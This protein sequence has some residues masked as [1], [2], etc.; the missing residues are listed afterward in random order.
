MQFIKKHNGF[1]LTELIVVIAIVGILAAIFISL[2]FAYI[3][4]TD[5]IPDMLM[6][7]AIRDACHTVAIENGETLSAIIVHSDGSI[8]ATVEG[9]GRGKDIITAA[10]VIE[11]VGDISFSDKFSG[12]VYGITDG[13]GE[14]ELAEYS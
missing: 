10:E 2:Y 4:R 5:E 14:W 1:T 3:S 9:Q 7:D 12:A 11:I 8:K 6:L 13:H